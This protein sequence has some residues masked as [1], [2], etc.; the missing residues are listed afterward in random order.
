MKSYE[1]VPF[2]IH[3]GLVVCVANLVICRKMSIFSLSLRSPGCPKDMMG[4][5]SGGTVRQMRTAH[6]KP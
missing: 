5:A 1:Q 3:I 4:G 6:F 2:K